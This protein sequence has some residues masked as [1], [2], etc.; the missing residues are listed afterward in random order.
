[1]CIK[2][3]KICIQMMNVAGTDPNRMWPNLNPFA[4]RTGISDAALETDPLKPYYD[5]DVVNLK[6]TEKCWQARD[7]KM[8]NLMLEIMNFVLTMIDLVHTSRCC[9][10][11]GRSLDSRCILMRFDAF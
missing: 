3:E 8:M 7:A 9:L 1:M 2:N 6:P 10:T 5:Q 4:N 11:S